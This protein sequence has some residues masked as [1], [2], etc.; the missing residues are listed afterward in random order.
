[1][2]IAHKKDGKYEFVYI[3][4]VPCYFASVHQPKDMHTKPDPSKTKNPSTREYAI[5]VFVDDA[6]REKL[7][8]EILINKQLFKTGKDKNKKRVI[9]YKTSKQ[10]KEGEKY[11]YDDVKDLNGIQ[12]TRKE[13]NNAGKPSPVKVVGPDGKV[14]E[15]DIGNLSKVSIKLFGYRNKEGL[16]N[17]SLDIVKVEEHVPYEGGD[18]GKIVDDELGIDTELPEQAKASAV[19][20]EFSDDDSDEIPF[21]ADDEDDPY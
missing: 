17:V 12:L 8:D 4:N 16:L 21:D 11:H 3:K 9:K 18:S 6:D 15:E 13:L 2:A 10:L 1:M 7:E 20:D 19:V 5:T 14:F